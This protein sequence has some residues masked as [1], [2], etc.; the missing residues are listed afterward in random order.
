MSHTTEEHSAPVRRLPLITPFGFA[1][2]FLALAGVFFRFYKLDLREFWY[3][4][5]IC[6]LASMGHGL[7]I[8]PNSFRDS[9][10][11]FSELVRVQDC[12]PSEVVD[13][14]SRTH[15]WHVPLIGL[16]T[17]YWLSLF[18]ATVFNAR[19]LC[20]ILSL[21]QLPAA[22]WLGIAMTGKRRAGLCCLALVSASPLLVSY[23]QE[24]SDYALLSSTLIAA[25]AA[26]LF[27]IRKRKL[28]FW[29]IYA[30]VLALGL[31]NSL[32]FV[33]LPLTQMAYACF[34]G[35][36]RLKLLLP[37][38]ACLALALV[39]SS[40]LWIKIFYWMNHA[41]ADM[42]W[43]NKRTEL[44]Y[45]LK[46]LID[47]LGFTFLDWNTFYEKGN[48]SHTYWDLYVLIHLL[49]ILAML[50]CF[51]GRFRV[52]KKL[53]PLSFLSNVGPW[54][55]LD[56]VRSGFRS[57]ITRYVLQACI[58]L[59]VA[60]SLVLYKFWS[61]RETSNS[62]AV[63]FLLLF[64]LLAY[65]ELSSCY[66]L[67]NSQ[68][69]QNRAIKKTSLKELAHFLNSIQK[70]VCLI[71]D[72]GVPTNKMQSVALSRYLEKPIKYYYFGGR[73]P[74]KFDADTV[75][76]AMNPLEDTQQLI[77]KTIACRMIY[78]TRSKYI[79]EIEPPSF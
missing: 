42:E 41:R 16:L 14:F 12:G 28:L 29:A 43:L 37:L 55:L 49:E 67:S 20:V 35:R 53:L 39:L 58:M 26:F 79:F 17:H 75:Y 15:T 34:L 76:L 9:M 11:I 8:E 25:Q 40:P 13:N 3:D 59:N 23:A 5:T 47:N 24:L 48:E 64:C 56:L 27:A 22:Y 45:L 61:K 69:S 74:E 70:P 4:E 66:I 62:H 32:H 71:I 2:I 36:K 19:L 6:W 54:L 38:L 73:L 78:P 33:F 46:G 7:P 18:G 68:M 30:L 77:K 51:R 65:S 63:G 57:S 72:L 21:F 44:P 1:L 31:A 60:V 50:F 10:S 52:F